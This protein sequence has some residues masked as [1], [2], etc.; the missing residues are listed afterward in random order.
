MCVCVGV[1]AAISYPHAPFIFT[2]SA[3]SPRVPACLPVCLTVCLEKRAVST[4]TCLH[5]DSH[6]IL[7]PASV[8]SLA[9]IIHLTPPPIPVSSLSSHPIYTPPSPIISLSHSFYVSLSL[10]LTL[11]LNPQERKSEGD[12]GRGDHSRH[13][14]LSRTSEGNESSQR[15]QRWIAGG[16]V[17]WMDRKM[18]VGM[19]GTLIL[20]TP[21]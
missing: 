17:G 5:D 14:P 2:H 8:K 9:S 19:G 1:A 6:P 13:E 18:E 21:L 20:C 7:I 10:S 12:K 11:S 16:E 3:V 4:A 15:G